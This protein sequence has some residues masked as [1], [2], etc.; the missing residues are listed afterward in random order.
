M[1]LT[2]SSSLSQ[3][4]TYKTPR[5]KLSM[6]ELEALKKLP[7]EISTEG[8]I[9]T[10]VAFSSHKL[11]LAEL[12]NEKLVV[13]TSKLTYVSYSDSKKNEP[14]RTVVIRDPENKNAYMTLE[15]SKA[16]VERLKEKFDGENNFFE[17]SEGV[18]RLN[19]EA[20]AFVAG[21]L[22]NIAIDRNY[23]ASDTDG[24]GLIEKDEAKTLT[25]GFERQTNYDY[26]GKKLVKISLGSG[27]H[28]RALDLTPDAHSLFVDTEAS[29]QQNGK[30]SAASAQYV[31]FENSIE[32]ELEHTLMMDTN[33]DGKVTLEEGL[34]DKFG[35]N[36]RK[37]VLRD[38]NKFHQDLL[39]KY[40]DL[41]DDTKLQ[42][43]DFGLYKT[44]SREDE[45]TLRA[46]MRQDSLKISTESLLDAT[47][48]NTQTISDM[49]EQL[50]K[51]TSEN[52]YEFKPEGYG[53]PFDLADFRG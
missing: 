8:E 42:N 3:T 29:E 5:V 18:L 41:N 43:Y 23:A 1:S 38:M 9:Y 22:H 21:W 15:L 34:L 4:E 30:S 31:A 14:N 10:S 40:A 19:G 33:L 16:N 44:I 20:E 52:P 11:S 35:Q 7:T 49:F 50:Q 13:D 45:E 6:R 48:N 12:K 32:K 39:E 46:Q 25:I 53:F 2:I 37:N 27:A 17:R 51:Q 47:R 26:I 36:Y 24:N 28:Y